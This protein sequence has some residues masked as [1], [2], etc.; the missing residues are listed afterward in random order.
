VVVS[1]MP[2][3]VA[4]PVHGQ[5]MR[6]RPTTST[7]P[8]G[9]PS[10]SSVGAPAPTS[11]TAATNA[12]AAA[13]PAGDPPGANDALRR[14]LIGTTVEAA[15]QSATDSVAAKA[16]FG[17]PAASGPLPSDSEPTKVAAVQPTKSSDSAPTK[18]MT[19]EPPK[20]ETPA[21]VRR[22]TAPRIEV[23]RGGDTSTR[24]GPPKSE[25]AGTID[26]KVA[27]N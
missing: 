6:Y 12:A 8:I 20:T 4:A 10:L 16:A 24:T 3:P 9:S 27:K 1:D 5:T 26:S 7:P 22:E 2:T 14:T 23:V 18:I 13:R 19:A 21:P 17:T 25:V 11:A 15:V